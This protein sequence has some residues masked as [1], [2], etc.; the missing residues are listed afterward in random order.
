MK[1]YIV[2][3][4]EKRSADKISAELVAELQKQKI[5]YEL[6]SITFNSELSEQ[7]ITKSDMLVAVGGDGT[8]IHIAKIAARFGKPVLGINA[9]RVGYLAGLES[10][11]LER[12]SEI[13]EGKYT[14]TE[15]MMLDVSLDGEHYICLNDAVVSKGALSRIVDITVSC[16]GNTIKY[17]ADG[18]I[19]ATPTGSTAYSMSAGGP[20]VDPSI[21]CMIVS[22]I[23]PHSFF[24][25]P[26]V[27]GDRDQIKIT[28]G[29][30]N[31]T[32]VC[33]TL[34]GEQV[35]SLSENASVTVK[36]SELTAKLVSIEKNSFYKTFSKKL[37]WGE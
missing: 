29:N 8:M 20:V 2:S 22:P 36:K 17:R 33:L 25:R 30:Q 18:V 28:A 16:G 14:V 27:I 6:D 35:V 26:L 5:E 3:N 31:A 21:N 13:N 10:D 24:S 37:K 4:S 34:D 23:C 11:E 1:F 12:I 19:V 15:R 32:R 9:G 7:K